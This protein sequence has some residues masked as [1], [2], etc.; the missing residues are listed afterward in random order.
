MQLE[1]DGSILI[2]AVTKV[3]VQ[4]IRKTFSRG[5]RKESARQVIGDKTYYDLGI[6]GGV[7]VFM[8]Q[9]RM[10][11]ATPGGA[12]LTISGAIRDLQ[13]QAVI[14]CGIAFG[15]QQDKQRLGD[16]LVAEQIKPYE[17]RKMDIQRDLGRGDCVTASERMLDRFHSGNNDW[18]KKAKIHF[19]LILSGEK[20]VNTPNFRDSL[21]EDE[22]EAIGGDMEGAGLYFAARDGKV[23]WI[24]I[25]G[26]SDWAD[27]KKNDK[28]QLL[29]ARNAAEFVLHVLRLG[30][31]KKTRQNKSYN[32]KSEQDSTTEPLQ[33]LREKVK[34]DI[35][36]MLEDNAFSFAHS[37]L[38]KLFSASRAGRPEYGPEIVGCLLE[39]IRGMRGSKS[40][41]SLL[42]QSQCIHIGS[43]SKRD[44]IQCI[45]SGIYD[46]MEPEPDDIPVPIVL[47]VMNKEE[48]L[49]L[50]KGTVFQ[51]GLHDELRA[52]FLELRTLLEKHKLKWTENYAHNLK[53][54]QPF[55]NKADPPT[56]EVLLTKALAK[57]EGFKKPL[58]P[59]FLDIRELNKDESGRKKLIKLRNG[60]VV[61][62]DIL[63]MRHPDIQHEFRQSLLD[64]FPHT[65]VASIPPPILHPDSEELDHRFV[66]FDRYKNLE[67]YKR[68][69]MDNDNEDKCREIYKEN[70]ISGWITSKVPGLLPDRFKFKFKAQTDPRKYW[71]PLHWDEIR[72]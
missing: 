18:R 19:G 37:V 61:I 13:P 68:C 43:Q 33:N 48:A 53:E 6:H 36:Q 45:W 30:G 58:S 41:G 12:L 17:S 15:L 51:S 32:Q 46:E 65:L 49:A 70:D 63:S 29:A 57:V 62:M 59:E 69:N 47:L 27:G 38:Q 35:S 7:R 5:S 11:T 31:W 60:C 9:S 1:T 66:I 52:D 3:E 23:D 21:L 50:E 10:G 4:A 16:I 25:K 14:M 28:N 72:S 34:I 56:I 20:L 71:Y 2:V 54:W 64:A 22:P 8:V 40:T 55:I 44:F 67:F 42:N 26:I 24:L 39:L